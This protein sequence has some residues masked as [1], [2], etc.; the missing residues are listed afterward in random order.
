MSESLGRCEPKRSEISHLAASVGLTEFDLGDKPRGHAKALLF[1]VMRMDRVLTDLEAQHYAQAERQRRAAVREGVIEHRANAKLISRI[2]G[3]LGRRLTVS[4]GGVSVQGTLVECGHDWC[5]LSRSADAV[6][7]LN[8]ADLIRPGVLLV[9]LH[10]VESIAGL[11]NSIVTGDQQGMLTAADVLRL[12]GQARVR[13]A[14][15]T[16]SG[17][18]P[19]GLIAAVGSDHIMMRQ[20][21]GEHVLLPL[22]ALLHAEP[23]GGGI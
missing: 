20:G 23:L 11:G 3:N 9:P 4:V 13:T 12:W 10:A 8:A 15:R 21:A 18:V 7:I 6:P 14:W 22:E 5:A 2:A 16:R 19:T 1:A 17:D